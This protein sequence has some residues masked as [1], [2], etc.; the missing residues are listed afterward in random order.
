VSDRLVRAS[1]AEA[2]LARDPAAID[3]AVEALA[4]MEFAGDLNA[5]ESMKRHL[6]GVVLRRAWADIST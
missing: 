1:V 5:G 6:A 4:E 3:A 2:V